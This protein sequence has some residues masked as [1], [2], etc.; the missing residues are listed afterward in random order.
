MIE[1]VKRWVRELG[2]NIHLPIHMVLLMGPM[3]FYLDQAPVAHI[4][5]VLAGIFTCLAFAVLCIICSF[6]SV[7][8]DMSL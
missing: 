3:I 2:S 1:F 7:K 5:Y 6:F 8:K 4:K